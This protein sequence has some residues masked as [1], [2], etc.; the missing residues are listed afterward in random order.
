M[1]TTVPCIYVVEDYILNERTLVVWLLFFLQNGTIYGPR[2]TSNLHCE[3]GGNSEGSKCKDCKT[4]YFTS[5]NKC[6]K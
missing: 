4:G 2:D 5:N 3:C 6:V 1:H